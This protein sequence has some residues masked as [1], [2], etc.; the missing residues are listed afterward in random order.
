MT[1]EAILKKVQADFDLST[2]ALK[3]MIGAFHDEMRLG[4]EGQESSLKMLPTFVDRASGKERGRF[5]R[6]TWV[7]Q[8]SAS[9]K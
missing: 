5:W 3:E 6:W 4:L 7:A 1:N 2:H 8:T 9:C